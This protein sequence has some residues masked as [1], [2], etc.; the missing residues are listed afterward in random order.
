M[1]ASSEVTWS[2][3]WL[4]WWNTAY[5]VVLLIMQPFRIQ[6]LVPK[7]AI[8]LLY[9]VKFHDSMQILIL[10]FKLF[11]SNLFLKVVSFQ[12]TSVSCYCF[13][14]H[15]SF[16]LEFSSFFRTPNLARR[17]NIIF[18]H[19]SRRYSFHRNTKEFPLMRKARLYNISKVS[20]SCLVYNSGTI[21]NSFVRLVL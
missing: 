18:P 15:P 21:F 16:F 2:F 5:M 11:L 13:L 14:E 6:D 19:F 8:K 1:L 10:Y 12:A 7:Y 4:R 9:A 17:N 20:T 3:C